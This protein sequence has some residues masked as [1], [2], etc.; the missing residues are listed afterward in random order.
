MI[1]P[2]ED[3]RSQ[4]LNNVFGH[5]VDEQIENEEE[6]K[7]EIDI[8]S[9][10]ETESSEELHTFRSSTSSNMHS[11]T[12]TDD[13]WLCPICLEL[14]DNP[15]ETPCC[16]NLFCEK[17]I[18]NLSKCP[19]C[20]RQLGRCQPNIP[21]RRLMDDL[22]IKCPHVKCRI[23]IRKAELAHHEAECEMALVNCR[24]SFL[25]G[26]I[27]KRDLE[28]HLNSDCLYRPVPCALECGMILT[29]SDMEKHLETDC[30]N[31]I[32]NCPQDC[33]I[34]IQRGETDVHIA[35]ICPYSY[36]RCNLTDSDSQSCPV[37]C[38]REEL[39]E[40]HLI[41]NFRKV[42]CPNHGC[43]QRVSHRCLPEH[44]NFCLF[45]SIQCPN[46]CEEHI[47]RRDI[48]IHA[49]ICPLQII[50]CPY[51]VFGCLAKIERKKY[52][53]HLEVEAV[54]H[55]FKMIEGYKQT[56][57]S[58]GKM[59]FE[60]QVMKEMWKQELIKVSDELKKLKEKELKKRGRYDLDWCD[61]EEAEAFLD[62]NNQAM[63]PFD[64][65]LRMLER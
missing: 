32:I 14:F 29:Y 64:E 2:E 8:E 43:N 28:K 4:D 3:V 39:E 50:D 61:E 22:A 27:I 42:R 17:C 47:L 40:H 46:N 62:A 10:Q 54:E 59:Q 44:Q 9:F 52:K 11:S 65:F 6:I 21:I 48:E 16:H 7:E 58:V 38:I 51:S 56:N 19:L 1:I 55:S 12:I 30:Q 57:L 60:I 23:V 36:V 18:C 37:L 15:V 49:A 31:V 20:S 13:R 33:G 53:D 26:D 63:Y 35:Q 34:L 24:Y 41:C 25:C 5:I 45:K